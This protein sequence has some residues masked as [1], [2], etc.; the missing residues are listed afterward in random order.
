[1][2]A[3]FAAFFFLEDTLY[4]GFHKENS[5]FMKLADNWRSYGLSGQIAKD[6]LKQE[7]LDFTDIDVIGT[8]NL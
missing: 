5:P 3:A 6:E 8:A 2:K 4:K 1:M 7:V